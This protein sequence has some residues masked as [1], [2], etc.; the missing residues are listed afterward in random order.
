MIQQLHFE[1]LFPVLTGSHSRDVKEDRSN[2][3]SQ[4]SVQNRLN[5]RGKYVSLDE[6]MLKVH[7]FGWKYV[8]NTFFGMKR[9][10][11]G[12]LLVE[13]KCK[14]SF[15]PVLLTGKISDILQPTSK[16]PTPLLCYY[17]IALSCE[18]LHPNKSRFS[19]IC[20]VISLRIL[21]LTLN[22]KVKTSFKNNTFM[23]MPLS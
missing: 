6:K 16:Q 17:S 11:K 13:N 4:S 1:C 2:W 22:R 12:V 9:C 18:F 14:A 5:R 7:L 3:N 23:W 15:Q 8:E 19:W 21:C 20:V 10:C